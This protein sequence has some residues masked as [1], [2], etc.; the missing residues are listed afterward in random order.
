MAKLL[1]IFSNRALTFNLKSF[2][3]NPVNFNTVCP[4]RLDSFYISTYYVKGVKASWT[5][6]MN[7]KIDDFVEAKD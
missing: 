1:F 7:S 3:M 2:R 5:H 6:S 4:R